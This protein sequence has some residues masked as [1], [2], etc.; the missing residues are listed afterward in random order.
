MG[1]NSYYKSLCA[2]EFRWRFWPTSSE[3][4]G[5]TIMRGRRQVLQ[6]HSSVPH[7]K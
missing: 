5:I 7:L 4:N 1:Y 2:N 6:R 3:V